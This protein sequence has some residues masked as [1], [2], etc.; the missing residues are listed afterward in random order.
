MNSVGCNI[1][2]IMAKKYDTLSKGQKQIADYIYKNYDKAA[3]MTASRLGDEVGISESTVVRFA[4]EL[5]YE[6][7]P[8][9]QKVLRE[10]IK[11]KLTSIQ[12]IEV[13]NDRI[14]KENILKSMLLQ[15]I[16]VIKAT[17]E[18]IDEKNFNEVVDS[19]LEAKKIYIIGVRSSAHLASFL[20]YYLNLIFDN[21]V[22]IYTTAMGEFFEQIIKA[23]ENDIVIGI[24]FPR[25]SRRTVKAIQYAKVQGAKSVAITDSIESPLSKYS[26][27]SLIARSGIASFVDSLVAPLSVINALIVA[28][29]AKRKEKI[30]ETFEKL[31]KIW[32]EYQV[33]EKNYMY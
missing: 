11:S 20:G 27:Y 3:F 28:I 22:L 8:G 26:D 6:G 30:C 18:D 31:E 17:L 25:Y 32:D 24:S 33:Y 14:K 12:R 16:D 13:S 15:D 29:G 21:V 10:M 2:D 5:G 23:S 19:I 7:Y 1:L 4:S 9:F